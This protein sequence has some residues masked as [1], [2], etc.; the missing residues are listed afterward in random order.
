ML[1]LFGCLLSSST[2]LCLCQ[3]RV[4]PTVVLWFRHS[5]T[6]AD[7]FSLLLVAFFGDVLVRTYFQ[8]Y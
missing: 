4:S 2:P 7:D 3:L 1:S 5:N 8:D 6:L